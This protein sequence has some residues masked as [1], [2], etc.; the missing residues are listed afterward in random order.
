M[1]PLIPAMISQVSTIQM[2]VWTFW[3]DHW[4]LKATYPRHANQLGLA[5]L[6]ISGRWTLGTSQSQH[7]SV[8]SNAAQQPP[9]MRRELKDALTCGSVDF[10]ESSDVC[11]RKIN[12]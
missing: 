10:G 8:W 9:N 3:C 5:L 4:E 11:E 7:S 6:D 1:P 2:M 12:T